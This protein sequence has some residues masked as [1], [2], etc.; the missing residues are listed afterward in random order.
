MTKVKAGE[1]VLILDRDVPV[2]ELNP[3]S[4]GIS[5]EDAYLKAL[6]AKGL[7]Q[8]GPNFGKKGK[9]RPIKTKKK[10]SLV[11]AVLQERREGW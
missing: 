4:S 10:V 11:D 5:G 7:V 9:P 8:L 3:L 1:S 6:V 2:A